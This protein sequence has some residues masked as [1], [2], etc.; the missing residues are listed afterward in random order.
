MLINAIV[1][2]IFRLFHEPYIYI[3][4]YIFVT[5]VNATEWPSVTGLYREP[6]ESIPPSFV[7]SL[8]LLECPDDWSSV[9][10]SKAP[11]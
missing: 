5:S 11:C 3:Y 1:I 2:T 8:P 4:I 6:D 7:T 10:G 9:P